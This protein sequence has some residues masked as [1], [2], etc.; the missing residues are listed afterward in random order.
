MSLD[1][2]KMAIVEIVAEMLSLEGVRNSRKVDYHIQALCDRLSFPSYR[3][4]FDLFCA[5][6][7]EW[8]G[9][10]DGFLFVPREYR[11][12]RPE[13][14]LVRDRFFERSNQYAARQQ[15]IAGLRS[16]KP[17]LYAK[18]ESREYVTNKGCG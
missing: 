5:G 7:V 4:F 16:E 1:V 2:E 6:V 18:H 12:C 3:H 11:Q 17:A 15:A 14:E 13:F 9:S 8:S 10:L